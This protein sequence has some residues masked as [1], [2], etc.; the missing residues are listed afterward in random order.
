MVG[1]G[2]GTVMADWD[3]LERGRG[4][5]GGGEGEQGRERD[6]NTAT[7]GEMSIR[8]RIYKKEYCNP[9]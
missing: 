2:C 5:C 9:E 3:I 1:G 7:E 4:M 8:V 6:P